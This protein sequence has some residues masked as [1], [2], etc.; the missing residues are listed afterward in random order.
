MWPLESRERANSS[1]RTRVTPAIS[2][3]R[4]TASLAKGTKSLVLNLTTRRKS[5]RRNHPAAR[6]TRA[7]SRRRRGSSGT[8][9]LRCRVY[10]SS[11]LSSLFLWVMSAGRSR[12]RAA[13]RR[14]RRYHAMGRVA[15]TLATNSSTSCG[16]EGGMSGLL[17]DMA[18]RA[19]VVGRAAQGG[20]KLTNSRPRSELREIPEGSGELTAG[21]CLELQHRC[22]FVR[23]SRN[24]PTGNAWHLAPARRRRQARRPW[25]LVSGPDVRSA[26]SND[27]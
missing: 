14:S 9:A 7:T 4:R 1:S 16:V 25:R 22:V 13:R 23:Q 12:R 21:L 3:E 26:T 2:A 19:P 15:L 17:V 18:S 6:A 24:F 10:L 20:D 8:R 11:G 5:R 27:R